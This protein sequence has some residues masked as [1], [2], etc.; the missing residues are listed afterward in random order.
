M[1]SFVSML[2]SYV[3]LRLCSYVAM[4][5]YGYMA[6]WLCGYVAKWPSAKFFEILESQ[7]SIDGIFQ[8]VPRFILDCFEV[9]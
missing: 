9:M 3:A 1:V 4:W 6:R 2:R 5:L 8:D 7:I